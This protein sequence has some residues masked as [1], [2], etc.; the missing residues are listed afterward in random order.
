MV[1]RV[2]RSIHA[3]DVAEWD[4]VVGSQLMLTHRWQRVMEHSRR[5]YEPRYLLLADR[6]GPLAVAVVNLADTFGRSGWRERLLRRL[7]LMVRA[8]YSTDSG[9]AVRPGVALNE[10][11]PVLMR[12]L[13]RLSCREQRPLLAVNDVPAAEL[14]IWRAQRFLAFDNQLPNTVLDIHGL[15][16]AEYLASLQSHQRRELGR[17]A[18]RA[19]EAGISF[20]TTPLDFADQRLFPL[21][22]EV[23][24]EHGTPV[25]QMPFTAEL[26][27][28]LLRELP[29]DVVI[30]RAT[31]GDRLA[32][33]MV[34]LLQGETVWCQFVGLHY[35]LARPL[36]L[37]FLL[38]H[39][40]IQWTI[41]QGYGR[42]LGGLTNYREKH[43]HG[44]QP[45]PRW[46]CVRSSISPLNAVL[47]E[48]LPVA[49]RLAGRSRWQP[50]PEPGSTV[51]T[52]DRMARDMS[53]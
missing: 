47:S 52:L 8:P 16:Q 17:M 32:G 9:I 34:G 13:D 37:Y 12:G 15:S 7:T 33:F 27:P 41:E 50:Q 35:A 30:V 42:V 5:D 38:L 40:F 6:Q 4:A 36:H 3:F 20:T 19:T 49:W 48:V 1:Y 22:A 44:F 53:R 28:A 26:F 39:Q 21:L 18:R 25:E 29:G 45:E 10:V 2:A 23:Y 46:L 43:K 11:L 14:P 24:A 31:L 51:Q